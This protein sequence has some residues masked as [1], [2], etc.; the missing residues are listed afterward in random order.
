MAAIP[1]GINLFALP[2]SARLSFFQSHQLLQSSRIP[3]LR[4]PLLH[5]YATNKPSRPVA[6]QLRNANKPGV[7]QVNAPKP[8]PSQKQG[9]P[10]LDPSPQT[11][12]PSAFIAF[13]TK[14][15]TLVYQAPPQRLWCTCAY[16]SSSFLFAYGYYCMLLS[17]ATVSVMPFLK[18]FSGAA[19]FALL[20]GGMY[21]FTRTTGRLLRIVAL[22]VKGSG[23]ILQLRLE[24]KRWIP[25]RIS[26]VTVPLGDVSL[27]H[28]RS[29]INVPGFE[30][31][32]LPI[33]EVSVLV[34]PFVRFGRWFGRFFREMRAVLT[35]ETLVWVYV[36]GHRAWKM[37]VRGEALAG[38]KGELLLVFNTPSLILC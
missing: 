12:N 18:F 20:C 28:K 15:S 19:G 30:G 1:R 34:R 38:A 21:I 8:K 10:R 9:L 33:S 2:C 13:K 26:S 11:S 24:G 29:E 17:Y 6:K 22:P 3:S 5:H 4:T 27:S 31:K 36:K 35:G 25:W 32:H 7:I 37:D 16:V 23:G 14:S